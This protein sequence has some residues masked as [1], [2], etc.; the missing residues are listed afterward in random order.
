MLNTIRDGFL[1]AVNSGLDWLYPPHC[2]HCG[3]SLIGTG[4]RIL[5]PSCLRE[6]AERRISG[7]ICP[8]CGGSYKAA[9]D[10]D[11]PC[12]SCRAR[13]PHFD[14]ARA[15]FA[16]GGPAGSVV[17]SFKFRGDFFLGPLL[18]RR[19]IDLNWL[20]KDLKGFECVVP[21]P[22]HARR[23]RERGYDQ[24]ALLGKVMARFTG[25]PLRRGALCRSRYTD[26]QAQLA[27]VK[28]WKNVQGAFRAASKAVAD[29]HV[30]LMDDVMTTGAT[31]SECARV[32][33]RAGAAKVSVLTLVRTQP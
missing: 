26:Q 19:A 18:L 31:A 10:L 9:G 22:L 25:V 13:P 7:P 21:V 15:L 23:E 20:P 32:L 6:L 14:L 11:T 5:C 30:L 1:S 33:K 2:Y 8:I 3:V 12:L 4:S 28:R 17:K 27:A 16:Y 24:A 29:R